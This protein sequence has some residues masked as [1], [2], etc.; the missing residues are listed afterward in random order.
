MNHDL[1]QVDP[2]FTPQKETSYS[3]VGY[4]ILGEILSNVTRVKYE[5]YITTSILKPLGMKDSTFKVP[6]DSVAAKAGSGSY[7]SYDLGVGI[8]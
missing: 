8:P 3:N 6:D 7:W 4:D 2:V 5:D 1:H